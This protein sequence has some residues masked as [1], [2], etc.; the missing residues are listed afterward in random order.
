[1][2]IALPKW[3]VE[4]T[5]RSWVLAVYGVIFGGLLPFLVGNWWFGNREKTKDGVNARSA[6]AFFKTLTEESGIDEVV[7][8]LSRSFQFERPDK[9]TQAAELAELDKAISSKLGAKWDSLKKVADISAEKEAQRRAFILLYAHLLRIPITNSTLRS[10]QS[11]LLL[12]TPSLLNSLLNISMSRNWLF[13]TLAVMRFHAYLT[14]ALVPGDSA[15]KHAQ[16]PGI[17]QDEARELSRE[18]RAFD[19]LVSTLED[20]KDGRV[21]EVKKAVSRWGT[22]DL[23]DASFKGA[24]H[25][26]HNHVSY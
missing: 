12:Q 18:T 1:M 25:R 24:H 2:G 9:K 3:I 16:L 11:D 14:Q 23:V 21:S 17:E 10:E 5:N 20:K 7:G 13:P 6:A 8:S 15:L 4:G 19:E 22:L 26:I